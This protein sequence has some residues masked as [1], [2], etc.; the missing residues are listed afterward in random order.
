MRFLKTGRD[1]NRSLIERKQYVLLLCLL[2]SVVFVF[3]I[4]SYSSAGWY[5]YDFSVYWRASQKLL[6]GIN[7]W[8]AE[9]MGKFGTHLPS[10]DCE[11]DMA[12]PVYSFIGIAIFLPFSVFSLDQAKLLYSVL[13]V[14]VL[15]YNLYRMSSLLEKYFNSI[16]SFM[17]LILLGPVLLGPTF[18]LLYGGSGTLIPLVGLFLC[19][20]LSE[21]GRYFLA[22]LLSTICLIK[23]HLFVLPFAIIVTWSCYEKCYRILLGSVVGVVA[24]GIV[25]LSFNRDF[26]ALYLQF[27]SSDSPMRWST[28]SL[29][30]LVRCLTGLSPIY[31]SCAMLFV[32]TLWI[33]P[34]VIK[35]KLHFFSLEEII[36]LSIPISII[37]APYSWTHDYVLCAPS[38][39]VAVD[40]LAK[41]RDISLFISSP[42]FIL[43]FAFGLFCFLFFPVFAQTPVYFAFIGS[44]FALACLFTLI[45]KIPMSSDVSKS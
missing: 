32:C 1:P 35:E 6:Q 4:L 23:P 16:T 34:K 45:K 44:S 11:N 19:I 26:F 30:S 38:L 5:L 29:P 7:P 43:L 9:V 31:S 24:C 3:G 13:A 14:L 28:S 40:R 27:L 36:S 37:C 20:H 21:R 39:I 41:G 33:L 42:E 15:T 22:G 10:S 17:L 2:F 12:L 18:F 8:Y 25:A